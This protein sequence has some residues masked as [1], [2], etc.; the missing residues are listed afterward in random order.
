M[1]NVPNKT[2]GK[3][4]QNEL[5]GLVWVLNGRVFVRN[6][7]K[8]GMPPLINPCEGVSLI[9]NGAECNHLITV[10]EKDMIELIPN[11]IE[12]GF[13]LNVEVSED[14]LKAYA[15]YT[16]PRIVKNV[17]VDASP[18]NKL[19]I[20]LTQVLLE[21][22]N[23]NKDAL[24][25]HLKNEYNIVYGIDENLLED[26]CAKNEAGKFL[27]AEGLPSEDAVDDSIEYFFD[28]S[29]YNSINLKEDEHGKVDYKNILN[30]ESVN[31]GQVIAQL[32]KGIGGI[33]GMD[34]HGQVIVA[35]EPKRLKILPTY[36]ASFNEESGSVKAIKPGRPSKQVKGDS[37]TIQVYDKIVLDE[38]SVKTGNIK[39]KGDIEVKGNVYES[40]EAIA[41][42]NIII[43]GNVNFASIFAGNSITIKGTVVSSKINAALN[44]TIAKDP[45]SLMEKLIEGINRLVEN[46]SSFTPQDVSDHKLKDFPDIIRFLLNDKN[47]DLPTTIY[48]VLSSLRKGNYDVEED[49]ILE[50]MKK[51]RSLMGNCSDMKDIHYL[52]NIVSDLKSL[53]TE[54]DTTKIKG[55]VNLSTI[56]NSDVMALGDVTISGKGSF[57][58]RIYSQGKAVISG[59]VRGGQIRAEKGIEVN[60]TGS[61]M[62][63]KT[64][65]SVPENSYI[66][67]KTANTDT[68][69]K[70]GAA[71]H[72]FLSE[73]KNVRARLVNGKL[74]V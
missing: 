26:I 17:I 70:I 35:R 18:V 47:K 5:D 62:G 36:T 52:N 25:E 8:I 10:S 48:E 51:T 65:L 20:T 28:D 32:H 61:D 2:K 15:L 11:D 53:F 72:T 49:F 3:L 23:V 41:K 19:D 39:F 69:I 27:I 55:N 46:L 34:V 68:T 22:K 37:I 40:M 67:I 50:F 71:S 43:K 4:N 33:D 38:I 6:E 59:D 13:E 54:K 60:T 73:S 56:L 30:Y 12:I 66:N 44:D 45:A 74:T 58:S 42:Q 31:P 1:F 24:L 64:F 14:K 9:I 57:N 7:M 63:A 21:T 29:D 16:P